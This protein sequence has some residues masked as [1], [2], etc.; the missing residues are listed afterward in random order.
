MKLARPKTPSIHSNSDTTH[1]DATDFTFCRTVL[2]S[3]LCRLFFIRLARCVR[4]RDPSISNRGS[5]SKKESDQK[6][7]EVVAAPP[8]PTL[9]RRCDPAA[10]C[11]T[12]P[13]LIN[14]RWL[15][16][17]V[18]LLRQLQQQITKTADHEN[19]RSRKHRNRSGRHSISSLFR[20]VKAFN[21]ALDNC[22][23]FL[24][25]NFR[26]DRQAQHLPCCQI[27]LLQLVRIGE[28]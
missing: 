13:S 22:I 18:G 15:V 5:I 21:H 2:R 3:I 10:S 9:D 7:K 16:H 11:I 1:D 17:E 20:S 27:C 12:K 4:D 8:I 23:L 28:Q 26:E 19:G 14:C 6:S 25:R 24:R